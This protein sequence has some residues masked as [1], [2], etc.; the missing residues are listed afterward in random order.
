MTQDFEFIVNIS[1]DGHEVEGTVG[2]V[3]G[4]S[5]SNVAALLDKVGRELEHRHT[6]DYHRPEPARWRTKASGT[7]K[8]G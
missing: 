3:A 4:K 6:D 5:C 1:A 8:V 7:L 2:G